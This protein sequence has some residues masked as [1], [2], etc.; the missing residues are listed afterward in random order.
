MH[1]VAV[2]DYG[3]GNLR[4][5]VK[6]LEHVGDGIQVSV[7]AD[8]SVVNAAD[9]VVFPGQGAI[10]DC[11]SSLQR[12]ELGDVITSALG[13]K[14]F[15]GICVGFQ[16]LLSRSEEDG[17][18]EALNVL[19]GKVVRFAAGQTNPVS[20]EKLK[21]PHMGWNQ[22]FQQRPHPLWRDIDDGHR[23]YFVHSYY[24]SPADPAATAGRSNYGVDFCS[25]AAGSGW[26][27]TQFHPDKSA[28]AGL[29]LL[30]NFLAWDGS[31]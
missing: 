28:H 8:P 11:M 19:P 13:S 26:F 7:T 15:L 1:K 20:S 17:G 10:G 30:R 14:P 2:I 24:V 31:A 5:V 23:F 3:M 25:A 6:A 12:L 21:V 29:Q 4:S 27:A 9:R 16:A 18:T 22:V